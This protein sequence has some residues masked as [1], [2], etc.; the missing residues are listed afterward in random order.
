MRI[1]EPSRTRY[2]VVAFAVGLAGVTYLDRN[3]ISILAPYISKDLGLSKE[4]MGLVFT[5]FAIAYAAFEIPTAAWGEKMGTRRV[6]ARIVA[7]WSIFTIATAFAWNYAAMLVIRFLFGAG[8]AGAWPNAAKT[9]AN[10]IPLRERGRVQGVFFAG[11]HLAGGITPLLVTALLAWLHWRHIFVIFGLIGFVWAFA[12]YRWFRDQ[13]SQHPEVNKAEVELIEHGRVKERHDRGHH[14]MWGQML[15]QR[16]F[17]AICLSYFSNSYGSYFVMT[18]L[19]TYLA[20]QR[21]FSKAELGFFAGLPLLLSVAG[22]L[23]GGATTDFMTRRLGLRLGRIATASAGYF[24][25]AIAMLASTQIQNGQLAAVMIAVAVTASMFT[26]AASWS[27][28]MDV[29]GQHTGVLS[30]SMNTTGQLGSILSPIVTVWVA[31]QF[32]DWSAPLMLMAALYLASSLL[33]LLVNPTKPMF[34]E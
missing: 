18:W 27:V 19:P 23:A 21:G 5:V 9:F 1:V 31:K 7:W 25:A 6:L 17:W 26:L 15:G 33:W 4:Q 3:C 20:E 22:D 11:A 2:K 16:N 28:C 8:E 24:L 14:E 32:A 29:G 10:W 34:R 13:P 12:W 30:A